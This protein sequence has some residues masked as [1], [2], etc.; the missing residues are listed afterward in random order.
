[1]KSVTYPEL[2]N[3]EQ[4]LLQYIIHN[5]IVSANPVAS[6]TLVEKHNLNI[7]PATVRNTMNSL[8]AKGL[9]DHPHTSAGRIPT[10]LGYRFYVNALMQVGRLSEKE[11]QTL[12]EINSIIRTDM[13]DAVRGAARTLARLS[14]LLAVVIAPRLAHGIFRK[15]ELVSLSEHRLMIILTIESGLVRTLTMEVEVNLGSTNLEDIA[16]VLNERFSGYSLKE[17]SLK[18]HEMLSEDDQRD[19]SGLIRFFIDSA[20]TIFEDHKHRNFQFGGIEYMAMQ[21]EFTDLSS[22]KSIVELVENEDLI[23]HILDDSDAASMSDRDVRIRIG[24]ENKLPQIERCSVVSAHYAIGSVTGTIGLVGPTRMD[25]PRMVALVEQ[26]A[27]RF[28]QQSF[29]E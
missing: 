10:E 22:Y 28:T 13:D 19:S 9:L 16:R 21:P 1:M 6:K 29:Y 3:R 5:F 12:D 23:I 7:S 14:H 18:S 15:I 26:L 24:T 17:I 11:Q 8:E 27:N 4:E 25:Y 20:D 2:N